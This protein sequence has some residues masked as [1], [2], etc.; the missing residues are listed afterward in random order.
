M[1]R[2]LKQNFEGCVRTKHLNTVEKGLRM[3]TKA[4]AWKSETNVQIPPC[5]PFLASLLGPVIDWRLTGVGL[6]LAFQLVQWVKLNVI[7]TMGF[8]I[9]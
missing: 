3:A 6:E 9:D 1:R 7:S 4:T 8:C 5:P 2:R